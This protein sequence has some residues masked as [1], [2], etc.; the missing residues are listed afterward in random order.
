[1]KKEYFRKRIEW[2]LTSHR[3]NQV[4][5]TSKPGSVLAFMLETA[6]KENT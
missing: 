2:A 5:C 1:M 4:I 3:K 6:L